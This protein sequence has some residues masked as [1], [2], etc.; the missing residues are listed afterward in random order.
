MTVIQ[1]IILGIIQGLSEFLPISSSGHLLLTQNIFGIEGELMAFDIFLHL[2]TLIPVLVVFRDD[3]ISLI[4][5][6]FQKMTFL[7]IIATLPAVAVTIFFGDFID[8]LFA[9]GPYLA[10]GFIITGILLTI[11]DKKKDGRKSEK[12]I[13]YSDA[14]IVGCVQAIA[15]MPGISRSGSTITGSIF[16]GF[17]KKT[18]ASFSFLMSIPAIL[19]ATAL[20]ILKFF[21]GELNLDNF[22]V[23]PAIAGFFA[24]MISGYIAIRFMLELI[25]KKKLRYFS[26][27]VYI[28]AA[29][30]LIDTF[31]VHYIF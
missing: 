26:V 6:P 31:F 30:I 5:N 10:I 24:A 9:G 25:R 11:S 14:L 4:K 12:N 29:L 1:G 13:T 7:L 18:A 19:G 2:G 16:R 21:K 22:Y 8:M 27:Y 3:I 20:Q 15:I 17:D 28:L 23:V